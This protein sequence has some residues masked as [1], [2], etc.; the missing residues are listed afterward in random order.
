VTLNL[1]NQGS[2]NVDFL[3]KI[4]SWDTC[5]GPP[6]GRR[7][8]TAGFFDF[9]GFPDDLLGSSQEL[10]GAGRIRLEMGPQPLLEP[11]WRSAPPE[12]TIPGFP[13]D[14]LGCLGNLGKPVSVSVGLFRE[15]IQNHLKTPCA[16]TV[17]RFDLNLN[18]SISE[19]SVVRLSL[20]FPYERDSAHPVLTTF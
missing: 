14:L 18:L 7:R 19:L 6:T 5:G 8:P 2:G 12:L 3:W 20:E 9:N 10:A 1:E 17:F 15:I 11:V 16:S 13:W 4:T